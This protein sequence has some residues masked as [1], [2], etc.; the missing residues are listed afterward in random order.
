MPITIQSVLQKEK[1]MKNLSLAFAILAGFSSFGLTGCGGGGGENTVVQPAAPDV[2][3]TPEEKAAF[4]AEKMKAYQ[5][6]Q[7]SSN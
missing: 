4:D 5:E 1:M 3:M 7:K 2:E 6:F